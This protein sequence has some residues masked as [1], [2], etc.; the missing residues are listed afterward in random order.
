MP[1]QPS[2]V[3]KV[4]SL[5]EGAVEGCLSDLLNLPIP[6]RGD[7]A[8][9]SAEGWAVLTVAF[10][11]PPSADRLAHLQTAAAERYRSG[12]APRGLGVAV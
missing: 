5:V 12:A 3:N 6:P 9:Y 10:P 7:A 2:E 8:L 1:E 11:V 4:L